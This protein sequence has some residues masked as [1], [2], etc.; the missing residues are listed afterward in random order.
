MI[1]GHLRL[2]FLENLLTWQ[3]TDPERLNLGTHRVS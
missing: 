2:P 3:A 1:G